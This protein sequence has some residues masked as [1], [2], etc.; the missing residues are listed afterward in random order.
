MSRIRFVLLL[1]PL[2]ALAVVARLAP[3]PAAAQIDMTGSWNLDFGSAYYPSLFSF[4]CPGTQIT[5]NGADLTINASCFP[6]PLPATIDKSTGQIGA[7]HCFPNNTC[8][9]LLGTATQ[10]TIAGQW[11]SNVTYVYGS[12]SG[13]RK[14]YESPTPTATPTS[15]HTPDLLVLSMQIELETGD[16]C[17]F[18]STLLGVRVF[19][20]NQGSADAGPFLVTIN[21]QDQKVT[22]LAAGQTVSLWFIGFATKNVAL[23]DRT[24]L[25]QEDSE[26]NNTSSSFLGVPTLPATCTP[27]PTVTP[28]AVGG[29]ALDAAASDGATWYAWP[30]ALGAALAVGL[31]ALTTRRSRS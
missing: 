13:A 14:G 2:V 3:S 1:A 15:I 6:G 30:L 12:F 8:I 24:D 18:T 23:L 31:V 22:G 9:G 5:Q 29:T 26:T 28:Q 25:V 21:G 16:S 17:A 19:V 10:N 4:S 11:Q 20:K 7:L 27:G